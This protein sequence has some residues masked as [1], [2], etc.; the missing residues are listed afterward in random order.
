MCK[1]LRMPCESKIYY[2][3]YEITSSSAQRL[4]AD[5]SF[6]RKR[7]QM[8]FGSNLKSTCVNGSS[9]SN[10]FLLCIESGATFYRKQY[11][12][13][14]SACRKRKRQREEWGG[15]GEVDRRTIDLK[16]LAFANPFASDSF[17]CNIL[18]QLDLNEAFAFISTAEVLCVTH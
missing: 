3:W 15:G 2:S 8:L 14:R 7:M 4:F 5:L 1:T 10:A 11:N 6:Q 17:Y 13:T 9:G 16:R 18:L 12:H